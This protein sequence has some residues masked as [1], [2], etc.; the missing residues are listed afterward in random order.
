MCPGVP[1]E[2]WLVIDEGGR[3]ADSVDNVE[4]CDSSEEPEPRLTI[5]PGGC[6]DARRG[7]KVGAGCIDAVRL[8]SG[9]GPPGRRCWASSCGDSA[10][11]C[12]T[13]GV[14]TI[15]LGLGG[16]NGLVLTGASAVVEMTGT[17][18]LLA[19]TAGRPGGGGGGGRLRKGS[20]LGAPVKLCC[21]LRAAILSARLLNWG[22]SV[23]AMMLAGKRGLKCAILFKRCLVW[24]AK[25][26]RWRCG[27]RV[28]TSN[29]ETAW[30][31]GGHVSCQRRRRMRGYDSKSSERIGNDSEGDVEGDSGKKG[32]HGGMNWKIWKVSKDLGSA[33]APGDHCPVHA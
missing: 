30:R 18:W 29:S 8:G 23:S 7:G 31:R 16:I 15:L 33:Q 26:G 2:P 14:E 20:G 4:C 1:S 32:L 22:S 5:N 28:A 11:V 21:F 9:G 19:S 27:W 25:T 3:P 24:S 12:S 17:V 6:V 13:A 10:I